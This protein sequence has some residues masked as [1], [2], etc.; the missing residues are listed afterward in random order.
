M[1]VTSGGVIEED[2]DTSAVLTLAPDA[3]AAELAAA[4]RHRGVVRITFAAMGDGRGF[5]MAWRLRSMGFAGRLRAAGPVIADQFAA[6]ARVGFDEAEL[7]PGALAR[8]PAGARLRAAGG[9]RARLLGT[10]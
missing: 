7:P 4:A 8:L 10:G 9:Y 3:D 2:P 6:L 1:L 5:S